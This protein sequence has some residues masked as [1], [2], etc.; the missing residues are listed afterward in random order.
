MTQYTKVL[1]LCIL[2][3]IFEFHYRGIPV[4]LLCTSDPGRCVVAMRA[5]PPPTTPG[6]SRLGPHLKTLRLALPYGYTKVCT[7]GYP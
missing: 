1:D 2:Y 6:L 4:G 5:L 7:R 3:C